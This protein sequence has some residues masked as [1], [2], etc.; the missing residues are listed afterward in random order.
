MG[1]PVDAAEVRRRADQACTDDHPAGCNA[2]ALSLHLGTGG[3]KDLGRAH[4]LYVDAC[5]AGFEPACLNLEKLFE[6]GLVGVAD[7]ASRLADGCEAGSMP[8]C[9]HLGDALLEVDPA[10]SLAAY[11]QAC[12]AKLARG[13]RGVALASIDDDP[14][15]ALPMLQGAC[16]VGEP[17]ACARLGDELYRGRLLPRDRLAA[18]QAREVACR[19]GH[20]A[21]CS[22]AATQARRG[23]GVPKDRAAAEGL[24]ERACALG[25]LE[26]CP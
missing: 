9:G 7:R 3:P 22:S 11:R 16:E 4:T 21:A 10:A 8:A 18:Y 6:G 24:T 26:A 25:L 15:Q 14:E 2:L 13:C 20:A 12:D 19:G 17:Q 5:E 23:K 1:V